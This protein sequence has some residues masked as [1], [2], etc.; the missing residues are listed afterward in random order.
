MSRVESAKGLIE[1]KSLLVPDRVENGSTA[2]VILD[3]IYTFD[4]EDDKK[5]V[6]KWFYRSDSAKND[7]PVPLYQWIPELNSR[8]LSP[9]FKGKV[10]LDFAVNT[11][12]PYTTFRGE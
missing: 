7:D 2:S 3:C 9:R 1:I 10:N 8:T 11:G 6:V 4:A 5:L 12:N